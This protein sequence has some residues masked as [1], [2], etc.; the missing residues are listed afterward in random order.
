MVDIC[1]SFPENYP[2]SVLPPSHPASSGFKDVQKTY[3]FDINVA[4]AA[5]LRKE[6]VLEEV[7]ILKMPPPLPHYMKYSSWTVV[8]VLYSKKIYKQRYK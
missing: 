4:F 3:T 2:Y 7:I 8:F 6:G 5:R 1:V